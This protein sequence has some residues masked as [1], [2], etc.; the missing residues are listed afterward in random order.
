MKTKTI[1]NEAILK[2]AKQG[3]QKY[4]KALNKLAKN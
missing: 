3:S 2:L 1:N 4:R